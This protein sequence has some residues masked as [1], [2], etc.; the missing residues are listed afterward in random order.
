ML[1]LFYSYSHT[2]ETFRDDMERCLSVLHEN[3]LIQEW[4]DRK[5]YP[6][7]ELGT[8]IDVNLA[9]ADIILLLLSAD[10]LASAECQKEVAKSL[11]Q[12]NS[13]RSVVVP[14]VLRPCSWLSHPE[15]RQLL[16]L[17]TDGK[18]VTNLVGP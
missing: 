12:R 18:P 10:F 6:G 13:G 16:A 7:Q 14:I 11:H 4:H 15:L 17:P 1:K 3:G 2:D 9:D 5:I 8:E